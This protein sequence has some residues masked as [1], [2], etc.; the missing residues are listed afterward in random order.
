[1]SVSRTCLQNSHRSDSPDT[2]APTR[3]AESTI[4]LAPPDDD[5]GHNDRVK[6][7]DSAYV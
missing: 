3:N 5:G 6:I 2:G 7:A 4:P 1:M